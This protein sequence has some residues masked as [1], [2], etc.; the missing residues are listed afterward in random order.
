VLFGKAHSAA[1]I[2]RGSATPTLPEHFLLNSLPQSEALAVTD[3][4]GDGFPD[5]VTASL[6]STFAGLATYISSLQS[7]SC[8]AL[9]YF[10]RL[11]RSDP[12]ARCRR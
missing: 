2:R 3:V 7:R 10:H 6:D 1:G 12:A 8:N 5:I 11:H 9:C 4:N